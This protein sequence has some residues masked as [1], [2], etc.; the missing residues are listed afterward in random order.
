VTKWIG[1]GLAAV[2]GA[3]FVALIAQAAPLVDADAR[4]LATVLEIATA[5]AVVAMLAVSAFARRPLS[6]VAAGVICA[7]LLSFSVRQVLL[8]L[9]DGVQPTGQAVA[10]LRRAGLG[11]RPLWVIGYRETSIV[12]ATR[13]DAHLTSAEDAGQHANPGDA[14]IVDQEDLGALRGALNSR[15]LAFAPSGEPVRARNIGNGDR[16]ILNVGIVQLA[17]RN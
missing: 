13:T 1:V 11:N 17:A 10:A 4:S 6:R 9:A 12:F 3:A 8:P 5:I 16:V 14:L 15:D 7:L 2:A